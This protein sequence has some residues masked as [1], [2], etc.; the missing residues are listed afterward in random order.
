MLTIPNDFQVVTTDTYLYCLY[1]CTHTCTPHACTH[2]HYMLLLYANPRKCRTNKIVQYDHQNWVKLSTQ[3]MIFLTEAF[4]ADTSPFSLK[5][6]LRE[7]SLSND[8]PRGCSS[9]EKDS[10]PFFPFTSK[11]ASSASNRPFLLANSKIHT[12]TYFLYTNINSYYNKRIC[13]W[14]KGKKKKQTQ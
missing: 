2:T 3:S 8:V 5:T 13:T 1:V 11:G 6:G 14:R 10:I 9:Q 4:P 12:C 7:A